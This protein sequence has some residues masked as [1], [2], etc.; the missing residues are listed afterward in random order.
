MSQP[1]SRRIFLKSGA[2]ALA[3]LGF[4][5]GLGPR[6]LQDVALAAESN[7]LKSGVGGKKILIC[8]F[9]RGAVD[10]LSMVVPHGDADYYQLRKMGNGGIALPRTGDGSVLDLDGTFGLHP[11]LK[12]LA[13]LYN[14]GFLAPIHAVGSPHATRSHFDAQ[15]YMESALPGDKSGASGWLTR[16]I[17]NC[18]QDARIRAAKIDAAGKESAQIRA[19]S[20]TAQLPRSFSGDAS[21]LAIANLSDFGVGKTAPVGRKNAMPM[22]ANTDP[23]AGFEALYA[24]AVGDVLHGTGQETFDAL[25]LL[26]GVNP[27][28]YVPQNGAIYPRG[29]LGDSLRGIAQLI[30]ADVGLEIA[31]AEAGGWDT[32]VAQ[33]ASQGQLA[34]RLQELGDGLGALWSD[35]GDRMADVTILTMSE[36]GR[37]ARQNANGGTDHGHGTCF[38]ALGGNV[39]GGQVLGKWPGLASEQLH[40]SRDLAVTT[41]FRHVFG[42]IA[43]RH[44]GVRDLG[45]V[46]PNFKSSPNDFCGL[47]RA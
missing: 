33:G 6:F 27:Q 23:A 36:F 28:K 3:S 20:M 31:F 38:L 17:A 14:Q 11:A 47:M 18:P 8:V 41:D 15:D 7:R 10:G 35:L 43:A 13:P 42:E 1:L 22:A 19:V 37:T 5:P 16:A 46:F 24:G 9:L 26:E 39:A 4:A 45:A 44:L 34:R 21:A 29:R 25:K 12:A 32:H 30:K 2:L 40:E